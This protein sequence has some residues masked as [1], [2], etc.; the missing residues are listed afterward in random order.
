MT[1]APRRGDLVWLDFDPSLGHEQAGRR[2]ALVISNSEYN[3]R[4]RLLMCLPVTSRPKGYP[5]EVPLPPGLAVTGVVLASHVYTL[6][7][8]LRRPERMD[9][10]P[11]E[12]LAEALRRLAAII[13]Q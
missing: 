10:A 6:D 11:P 7:W 4:T 8:E 13:L 9:T 1:G 2:P 5:T 3:A 12:L